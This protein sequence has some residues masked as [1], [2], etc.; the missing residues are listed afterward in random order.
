MRR[1]TLR[2][3]YL[4]AVVALMMQAFGAAA[5]QVPPPQAPKYREV[6]IDAAKWI[7]ST[8]VEKV[9]ECTGKETRAKVT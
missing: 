9:S 5:P 1:A 6:A 4:G 2:L 7:R 3:V 8:R